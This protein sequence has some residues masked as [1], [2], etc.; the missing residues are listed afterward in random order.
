MADLIHSVSRIF[1]IIASCAG[2]AL[3]IAADST[4]IAS[5]SR[6]PAVSPGQ[7][8]TLLSD[9]SWLLLGGRTESGQVSGRAVRVDSTLQQ[10]QILSQ[11][12][13]IPRAEQSATVLPDGTVLVMGGVSASGQ[14]VGDL[15]R[16]HPDTGQFENLGDVGLEAR[17]GHSATLLSDGRLL[18]VGGTDVSSQAHGD[19]Q[20]LDTATLRPVGA[21]AR[22]TEARSGQEAFLLPTGDVLIWGGRNQ[23]GDD[24]S[25]AEVYDVTTGRFQSLDPATAASLIGRDS[26]SRL[27]PTIAAT[28]P[29]SE[30]T[31]V[32]VDARLSVRFSKPLDPA[33]LTDQAITLIGPSGPVSATVTA[34]EAGRLAFVTPKQQLLPDTRYTLFVQG[35]KDLGGQTLPFTAAGFQTIALAPSS[36]KPAN[37]TIPAL[38]DAGLDDSDGEMWIPGKRNLTGIWLSGQADKARRHRPQRASVALALG[39]GSVKKG[40]PE[41]AAGVTAVAGQVLRLTGAPLSHVSLSIGSNST[42]TDANGEFLLT[43]VPSGTQTL[44]IDGGTADAGPR[45]YGR[46][47]Y[48]AAIE[49]GKTNALPFVIWMTRLDARHEVVIASPTTTETVVTNSHIPGLELHIPAGT[50]IRDSQGKIVTQLTMTAIPGDQPP[51]PLPNHQVPVYFTIQPGGAKLQGV[52]VQSAKGA[53]LIYPNFTNAAAGTR[54]DFWDYD[55]HVKGW[56]V[57]GQGTVSADRKQIVPDADVVIYEFTGAMVA[58]DSTAPTDGP[59]SCTVKVADPVDCFTGL[60]I[61]DRMD[62]AINDVL[63]IEVRRTYRPRDSASRAFGIGTNLSYDMFLVG[64]T[65]PWTYQD[66]I[67]PD[68]GRIH[69]TRTSPGTG[70]TDAVYTATNAPGP[71]FNST[72]HFNGNTTEYWVLQLVDGTVYTFPE[73]AGSSIARCGALNVMRDRYGNALKLVRDGG[74]NLTSVTSPNGRKLTFTYDTSKRIT[75]AGD[76]IGRTVTY[77]YDTAGRLDTVTDPTNHI[78]AYT[79]D[80]SNRMLTV[81]DKRGNV[82]VTNAY[83]ANGRVSQQTYA[84]GTTSSFSYVL[85][86]NGVATQMDYTDPRG[87]VKRVQFNISGYPTSITTALGKPEQQVQTF[88]RDP[89]TNLTQSETDTLGRMTTYQYDSN[90]HVTQATYLS[91]TGGAVTWKYTYEPRYG[92]LA[93]VTD[94]LGHTTTY[95]YDVAGNVISLADPLGNSANLTYNP[96]GQLASVAQ[97]VAGTALTTTLGYN[98]GDLAS[99]TDPLGRTTVFFTDPVGRP[100]LVTDALGSRSQVTYDLL[101]RVTQS[102][103]PLGNSVQYTYDANGN[104]LTLQDPRGNTTTF[105]FDSRNRSTSMTDPLNQSETYV[106]DA[107][108]NLARVTDRKGQVAGYE[109]DFLN[110]PTSAGF[111]ASIA[112]PTGYSSTIA[113]TWDAGNRLTQALD[114]ASGT[115]ASSFDGLDRLTQEQSP[116]GQVSYTYY[117][118]GLRQSMTAQGQAA[119]SYTYDNADRLTQISQGGA[120]V[121]FT[122]DTANRRTSLTLPNGV[123]VNYGYDNG[124]QLTG[125]TY[126]RAGTS[127]GNLTYA[128]GANGQRTAIGGSLAGVTLPAPIA[129]GSY[130]AANRLT[131]WDGQ[132]AAYDNNGN[133]MSLGASSYVWNAR[134]QLVSTSDGSGAFTYDTYGRR[135]ARSVSGAATSYLHDGLNPVTING[136]FLLSGLAIDEIYTRSSSTSTTGFLTDALGSTVALTDRSGAV[137]AHYTYEPY[138]ATT[139]TGSEDTSFQYTGRENDSSTNLYYYRARYYLPQLGRFISQ[140]PIGFLGGINSYAYVGSNPLWYTDPLGLA[141]ATREAAARAALCS[142]YPTSFSQDLEYGGRIISV[143]GGFDFT[144]PNTDGLDTKYHLHIPDV[145]K[146][147][148]TRHFLFIP[149]QVFHYEIRGNTVG[150]Y[151][152]HGAPGK[153]DQSY[154]PDDA[155]INRN[156]NIPGWYTDGN[157]VVRQG[158]TIPG[159]GKPISGD[160]K[161]GR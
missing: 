31:G 17:N 134:N 125:I 40:L 23:R 60:F 123:Q 25:S 21:S 2:L 35:A 84:D 76:D 129:S 100:V 75:Q 32:P 29:R 64:D 161:C 66:L 141:Y 139:K 56:Y 48:R 1:I 15:E 126:Q 119:V 96:A 136:D 27:A 160:C 92:S 101:D 7:S 53:R 144:P 80:T 37:P 14:P 69:Y 122:Y 149:Y 36:P 106:Y 20:L 54:I 152:T 78:E 143:D 97:S 8:A 155:A 52:N 109:Y 41:A 132:T 5:K 11:T 120:A 12:L 57:Y 156:F 19:A 94:P 49:P 87:A 67:L 85:D 3:A 30:G 39:I 124:S 44:V 98:G 104:L 33:S 51:F 146:S 10:R 150:W 42:L 121:A 47:E 118:N 22:L 45:R 59:K 90:G 158:S 148:E 13:N 140:D 62:L 135:T 9:G 151:H 153:G 145:L 113:Y 77:H 102:T 157:G 105:S 43:N 95:S 74:C 81:T 63:P 50:V 103:D 34:A 73:A 58:L 61:H 137:T 127:L 72:I 116:Q 68:G 130:D 131:V 86:S 26:A 70:F 147:I 71:F 28:I 55:S 4:R 82:M 110:R 83:D 18:I 65:N 46:Y 117:A 16:Y 107:N 133:M 24:L 111:G 128:Y 108:G 115:I 89:A 91:G 159:I 114:S 99:V 38:P 93:S 138:G 154:S 79:Y 112:N 142:I 88:V 6:S